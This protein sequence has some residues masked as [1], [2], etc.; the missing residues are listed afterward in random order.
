[1]LRYPAE[2]ITTQET[3][4][5]QSV[6]YR[7][8]CEEPAS[9]VLWSLWYD[10]ATDTGISR[11]QEYSCFRGLSCADIAALFYQGQRPLR[12]KEK[13]S[14]QRSVPGLKPGAQLLFRVGNDFAQR[15]TVFSYI[16]EWGSRQE[17]MRHTYCA[18]GR[19][20]QV[21]IYYN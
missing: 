17:L 3:V 2:G 9:A 13:N 6:E 7:G 1:M 8:V 10:D 11:V 5:L 19:P 21:S 15:P 14:V 4:Y 16:K 18:G 20:G 12:V